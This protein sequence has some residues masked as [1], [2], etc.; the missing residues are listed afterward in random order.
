MTTAHA[1]MQQ[2]F[3][4]LLNFWG[5]E[6]KRQEFGQGLCP[7]GAHIMEETKALV[8]TASRCL[9][10]KETVLGFMLGSTA[11]ASET[12][13]GQRT[14]SGVSLPTSL[15]QG[16]FVVCSCISSQASQTSGDS[17]VSASHL[18]VGVLELQTCTNISSITWLLGIWTWVFRL[19]G[20]NNLV[21]ELHR[22]SVLCAWWVAH[23]RLE[24]CRHT[25]LLCS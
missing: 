2:M 21:S 3:I 11:S 14:D 12:C 9:S 5:R 10:Y 8:R 22:E 17:P 25:H 1:F 18:S 24:S 7:H 19:V 6:D 23:W 20:V 15:R 4:D 16:F 13:G